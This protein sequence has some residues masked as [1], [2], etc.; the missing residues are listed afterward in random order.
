MIPIFVKIAPHV[1]QWLLLWRTLI[2]TM[3][4]LV[5]MWL[6]HKQHKDH[7]N[8]T[9]WSIEFTYIDVLRR[10]YSGCFPTRPH[11]TSRGVS[12][13]LDCV[14]CNNNYEDIFHA[15]IK[16]P[17]AIQAWYDVNLW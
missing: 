4:S 17:K 14:L 15:L 9:N 7:W 12:C 16:C 13:S 2:L 3:L 6:S 11:L 5:G 1:H 10:I 8:H